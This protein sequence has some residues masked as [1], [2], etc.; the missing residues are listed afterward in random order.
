MDRGKRDLLQEINETSYRGKRDRYWGKRDLVKMTY[1][2]Y[3][4]SPSEVSV[5]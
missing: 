3:E 4:K 2:I 1:Q 5:F